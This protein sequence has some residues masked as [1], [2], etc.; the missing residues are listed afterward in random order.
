[1]YLFINNLGQNKIVLGLFASPQKVFWLKLRTNKS[2]N[3][4]LGLDKL[5]K[6]NKK[7]LKTLKG[8]IVV[9]GPGSFT[10]IRVGL[11]VA[12]TLA[13]SLGIPV[14]GVSPHTKR[15]CIFK[16][17]KHYRRS[18]MGVSLTRA[19][20]NEQLLGQGFKKLLKTKTSRPVMPF[21]GKEPNISQ[22]KPGY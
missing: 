9:N 6:Q 22:P 8:I 2:E 1:M 13:W 10:G 21:Y 11:S 20:D 19:G 3:L 17:A 15:R 4:L 14:I 18:G 7:T 16:N 5:L 12:N